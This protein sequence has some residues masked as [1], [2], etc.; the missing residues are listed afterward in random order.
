[1]KADDLA[2]P[3]FMLGEMNGRAGDIVLDTVIGLSRFPEIVSL[4]KLT[5]GMG[6]RK[7][8][9]MKC[10]EVIRKIISRNQHIDH[11]AFRIIHN[12]IT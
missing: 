1:M 7:E 12:I 6:L 3:A 4:L 2:M 9:S 11:L 10:A 8:L 5:F